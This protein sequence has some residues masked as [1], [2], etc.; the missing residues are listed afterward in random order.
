MKIAYL[1]EDAG[2]SGGAKVVLE[3]CNGLQSRGHDVTLFTV[4]AN[5]PRDWFPLQCRHIVTN[6]YNGAVDLLRRFDGVKTATW[7][8]TAK[9]VAESGGRGFYLVQDIETSYVE[10]DRHRE[11]LSTY[12]LPLTKLT[13]ALWVKERLKV[14]KYIGIGINHDVFKPLGVK[15]NQN[16]ILYNYRNHGLKGPKLFADAVPKLPTDLKVL[17]F[18]SDKSGVRRIKHL[19]FQREIDIAKLYNQ[20]SVYVSSSTHEGFCIPIV[21]AMA[22]GCPVITTN[23]DANMEFCIDGFNCLVVD[24]DP[25]KLAEAIVQV[26][27]NRDLA[28]SLAREG[29][30]TAK[31]YRWETVFDNLER[32]YSGK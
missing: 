28:E 7:W 13:E 25:A 2:C 18:G 1:L 30:K 17:S 12:E 11:V 21:E 5:N 23:A 29:L 32:V 14:C 6:T 24:R 27:S 22:C 19:G 31:K 8:K 4:T 9:T 16:T 3:H 20:A 10:S 26:C 15:R